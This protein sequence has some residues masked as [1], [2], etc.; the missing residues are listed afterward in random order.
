MGAPAIEAM[1]A[2]GEGL[3]RPAE[4]GAAGAADDAERPTGPRLRVVGE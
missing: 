2:E 1:L 3:A 4:P